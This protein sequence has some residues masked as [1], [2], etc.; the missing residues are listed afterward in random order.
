MGKV[1]KLVSMVFSLG[2]PRI[3][4]NNGYTDVARVYTRTE[5]EEIRIQDGRLKTNYRRVGISDSI[6][7][8]REIRERVRR[9]RRIQESEYHL[10]Y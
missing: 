9:E 8:G 6:G 2:I 3:V 5:A 1:S 7:V 10:D 4:I